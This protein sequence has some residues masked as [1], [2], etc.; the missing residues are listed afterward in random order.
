MINK[1]MDAF[2]DQAFMAAHSY[3]GKKSPTDRS[4]KPAK[5]KL[6]NAEV[7]AIMSKNK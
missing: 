2:W 3:S 7:Q 1:L 5:Q 4:D 6:P